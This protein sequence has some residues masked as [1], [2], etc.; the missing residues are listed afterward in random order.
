MSNNINRFILLFLLLI[1]TISLH[2]QVLNFKYSKN[3]TYTIDEVTEEYSKL[4][5]AYPKL[6]KLTETGKSDIGRPIHLFVISD[7][8]NFDPL[9]AK[10]KGKLVLFINNGIHAGEPPGV[11]ASV[12]FAYKVLTMPLLK[13]ILKDI[14]ICIIPFYNV[15]GGL[16]RSC[17][18]RANQNGPLEYG[19]RGNG[20]NRD[21]N[22]DFIKV[23]TRNTEAFIKA[24]QTWQPDVFIDTHD[25]NGSDFQYVMTLITSQLNKQNRY[26]AEYQRKSYLPKLYEDM[27][28][29]EFEMIPY[30]NFRGKHLKA[31]WS[32]FW[33]LQ[34]ILQDTQ[35]C[36]DL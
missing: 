25:T 2:S 28:K 31:D 7:D 36:S 24:Y 3:E 34:D 27:R 10:Q 12:K 13:A 35:P 5:S 26:L 4:E 11:D 8:G 23:D 6:C 14:V 21:L 18:S 29:R 15:D 1:I 32:T 17:C 33:K 22:R 19:F 30:V 20:Q 16:N 9:T